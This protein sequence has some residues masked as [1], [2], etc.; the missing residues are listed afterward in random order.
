MA[1]IDDIL[2]ALDI[3][4]ELGSK[5]FYRQRI[6]RLADKRAIDTLGSGNKTYFIGGQVLKAFLKEL[7]LKI[8]SRFPQVDIETIDIF[9]DNVTG[10]R[11]VVDGIVG[12]AVSVN[13]DTETE[14][15]LV[16][17]IAS[18]LENSEPVKSIE[19]SG[20]DVDPIGGNMP[21]EILWIKLD[22]QS[23]E[24]V[25]VKSYILVSLPS[26]AQ[27]IGIRSDAFINWIKSKTF[28]NFILSAHHKLIHDTQIRVPW[29][30]GIAKG[31]TPFVPFELLPEIIVAFRQSDRDIQ[32]PARAEFLYGLAKSTLQA[33]GLAISGDKDSAAEVLAQVGKGLGLS[34]ADQIIGVFKQYESRDFQ[35]RTN[36]EFKHKV[37]EV[38]AEYALIT[39]KM[40]VGITE[41]T[42]RQ[43]KAIGKDNSL[44]SKVVQSSREIMRAI[45]PSDGVGMTFGEKH[46]SKD[47]DINEAIETGRQGKEFYSRLKHV[48]LL[49]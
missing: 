30:K 18:L 19:L 35:V 25:A 28:S 12:K 13:T 24:D 21:K 22:T 32:Y 42:A 3:E 11:L 5:Y 17:K 46:F 15:D 36:K 49:D 27:F 40:T 44:P 39:G 4:K 20:G 10:K 31:Y 7:R 48:G 38:G 29:K 43:W 45:S 8:E 41:L 6:Y 16:T 33:V 14:D 37:K 34:V 23:V 2:T 9:Y 47:P 26:I 1:F